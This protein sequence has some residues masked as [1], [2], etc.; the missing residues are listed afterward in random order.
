MIIKWFE[1]LLPVYQALLAGMFTWGVT[2]VGAACV[3]VTSTVDRKLLD[4]MLGFAVEVMIY[5]LWKNSSRSPSKREIWTWRP[6][7]S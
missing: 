1:R 4:T 6:S 7:L 5:V 2:A 3:F